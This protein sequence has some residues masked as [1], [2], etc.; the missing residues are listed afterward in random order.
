MNRFTFVL[1]MCMGPA[2]VVAGDG[3]EAVTN[4][5]VRVTLD[6]SEGSRIVG[7]PTMTS[8][9]VQS[10][11][12]KMDIPLGQIRNIKIEDDH[13]TAAFEM[14]NGD[15][16][17]GVFDLGPVEIETVFG[18]V[19][20]GIADIISMQ[21]RRYAIGCLPDELR[22]R[23]ALRLSFDEDEAGIARDGTGKMPAAR[24]Q[25][26]KWTAHGKSGGAYEFDG[27]R[28]LM[29]TPTIDS[30]GD[31]TWSVWIYPR[32]FPTAN[33]TYAQFLGARGHAW[34]WNS[35]NTSLSFSR[36]NGFG[37]SGLALQFV[38]QGAVDTSGCA[39]YVFPQLP[40][41]DRWYHVAGVID[42]TGTHLY[43]DGKLVAESTDKIRLATPCPLI[44]GAN[45]NGPQRYFD[46]LIDEVMIFKCALSAEEIEMLY[47][48]DR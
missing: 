43:M 36:Q 37:G 22:K 23:L 42:S 45:D 15:R 11:Y 18:T 1:A 4:R 7:S 10:P 31:T 30:T 13:E 6:L 3:N 9:L 24:A 46:G 5:A 19:K 27:R 26:A 2:F 28:D 25:G 41:A 16:L 29:T 35:D 39:A 14:V 44:I 33:D 12:A 48:T 8:V 38:V 20:V 47:E 40:T 32:S 21:V 34:V 17:T